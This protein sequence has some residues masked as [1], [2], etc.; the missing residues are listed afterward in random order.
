MYVKEVGRRVISLSKNMVIHVFLYEFPFFRILYEF[1][2]FRILYEF[3]EH[4]KS[5]RENRCLPCVS[6]F[7]VRIFSVAVH[8]FHGA[9]Q[10][11]L[12]KKIV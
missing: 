7:A 4:H 6:I 9:R 5:L 2:F 12:G 3:A 8:I 11:T 10:K 1:A